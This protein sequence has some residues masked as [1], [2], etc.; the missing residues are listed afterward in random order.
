MAEMIK[1]MER[2]NNMRVSGEIKEQEA[3][4]LKLELMGVEIEEIQKPKELIV[5]IR[6][7]E[8]LGGK[9]LEEGCSS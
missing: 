2:I 3:N 8:G 6:E 1:E 7:I 9:E 4:R 5:E